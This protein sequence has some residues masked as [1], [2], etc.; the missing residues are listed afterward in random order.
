MNEKK[1]WKLLLPFSQESLCLEKIIRGQSLRNKMHRAL[2]INNFQTNTNFKYHTKH[3]RDFFH[4]LSPGD[5]QQRE[6]KIIL[7]GRKE[8]FYCPKNFYCPQRTQARHETMVKIIRE[9]EDEHNITRA[10]YSSP[11]MN[12]TPPRINL[13]WLSPTLKKINLNKK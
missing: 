6:R 11:P 8:N 12:K 13:C 9:R 2:S 4:H 1:T 3:Q 7:Q 10:Q 5:A